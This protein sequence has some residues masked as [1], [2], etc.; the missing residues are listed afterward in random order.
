M[1][2]YLYK[3]GNHFDIINTIKTFVVSCYYCNKCN[4]HYNNKHRHRCSTHKD[5]CKL[6]AKTIYFKEEKNKIYWENYERYYFNQNCFDNHN[7]VFKEVYQCRDCNKIE[8]GSE[9]HMCGYSRCRNR[10]EIYKTYEH[11]CYM[12]PTDSNVY[13]EEDIFFIII[14]NKIPEFTDPT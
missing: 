8:L 11:K 10:N 6:C 1:K 2:I 12:L 9:K 3:Y 4:K 5:I 14:Q 7:D 13:T